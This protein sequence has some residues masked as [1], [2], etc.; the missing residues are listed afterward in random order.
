MIWR[1]QRDRER[2]H[3][4]RESAETG[5]VQRDRESEERQRECRETERVRRYRE[6]VERCWRAGWPVL[7]DGQLPVLDKGLNA[8]LCVCV[9]CSE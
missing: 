9:P 6:N 7:R 2:V 8:S 3:R 5:R 1:V 4:D